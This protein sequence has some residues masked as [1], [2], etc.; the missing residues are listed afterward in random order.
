MCVY[1]Y[2]TEFQGVVVRNTPANAGDQG[3][4]LGLWVKSLGHED[5]L[6]EEMATT[7]SSCLERG[8][9]WISV[10]GFA[11]SDTAVAAHTST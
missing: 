10:H 2:I 1:I 8:A 5:P 4:I 9:W 11:E 6:E 7:Q 3:S